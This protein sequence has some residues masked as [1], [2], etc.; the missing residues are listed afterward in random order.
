MEFE[1]NGQL[2][3]KNGL[4]QGDPLFLYLFITI[5]DLLQRMLLHND[6]ILSLH[7]PIF[8]H[9]PPTTLQYADDMLII[10]SAC[11]HAASKLKQILD[12]FVAAMGLAI[13]FAKTTRVPLY[14]PPD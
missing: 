14:V 1:G 13:N 4:R 7:H 11:V 12:T 3:Y 10:A 9:L 8:T 2:N 6:D 5:I